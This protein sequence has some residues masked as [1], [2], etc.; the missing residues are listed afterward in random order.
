[1]AKVEFEDFEDLVARV[2]K[3]EKGEVEK[4]KISI[5][6]E[7][8]KRLKEKAVELTP[9]PKTGLLKKSWVIEPARMQGNECV[10][11]VDNST[12]YAIY[13]EAGHR[14]KNKKGIVR[15][16]RM[17]K[18]SVLELRKEQ[19]GVVEARMKGFLEGLFR[20]N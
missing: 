9:P 2:K 17:L 19:R 1:M 4:L 20:G 16:R 15:G 7:L 12:E 8:A 6:N 14:K 18:K 3:A 11:S 5:V 10:A 13:V